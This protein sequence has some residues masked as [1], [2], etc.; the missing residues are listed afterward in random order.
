MDKEKIINYLAKGALP[1]GDGSKIPLQDIVHSFPYFQ[2]AQVLYAKQM[3]D[4]NDTEVATRVKLASAYAPNR[5]AMYLLFKRQAEK[6]QEKEI[7]AP[8]V[9]EVIAPVTE[10]KY[11]YVYQSAE[12]VVK[13][14]PKDQVF[15]ISVPEEIVVEKEP[16]ISPVSETFLENEILS[17][18]A[19]VQTEQ[20]VEELPIIEV[21]IKNIEPP[22]EPETDLT[23]VTPHSFQ[24]WLKIVPELR[25]LPVQKPKTTSASKT[26]DIIDNFLANQPRISKPKAEFFSPNK[27]AKLSV[28]EDESLVSETLAKIYVGQGNLYKALKAYESLM[29]Q[30][31]EKSTYFAARIKEI[32]D[33]IDLQKNK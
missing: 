12:P 31:P 8:V 29:L 17:N 28:N 30:N 22:A 33:K 27:A 4:D 23:L 16:E 25:N 20:H 21:P 10:E 9:V 5:K 32:R 13:E 6:V 11:N 2:A 19:A 7:K 24:D 3:Y 15:T 18:I 1:Q 26:L 14:E